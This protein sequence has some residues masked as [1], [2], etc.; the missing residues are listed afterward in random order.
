MSVKMLQICLIGR[1]SVIQA[2]QVQM[3]LYWSPNVKEQRTDLGKNAL[4]Y[5][6]SNTHFICFI[7]HR[8]E[9]IP[10]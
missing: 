6:V 8:A 10:S 9:I 5:L 7:S 2:I 4:A 3:Q 1:I